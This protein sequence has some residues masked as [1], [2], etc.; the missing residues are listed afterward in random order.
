MNNIFE[1]P[2]DIFDLEEVSGGTVSD[3][4][5]VQFMPW[6][7]PRKQYVRDKQWWFHLSFLIS[8]FPA[9]RELKVIKYFGLP[10]EELLDVNYLSKKLSSNEKSSDKMLLVHGFIDTEKGKN[11]AEVRLSELL[12]RRNISKDSKVERFNFHAL[13][14][15]NSIAIDKIK[16]NGAY[17]LINLDFCDAIFKQ[18]TIDSIMELLILQF[19]K[20]IDTPWLLFLTTRSDGGG[21]SKELLD[22]LDGIFKSHICD[23]QS[24]LASL[25]K[26]KSRIFEYA[27]DKRSLVDESISESD[28]SEILQACLI[29]WIM[30]LTHTNRSNIEVVSVMKYHVYN[31]NEFPDMFSYV[32]RFTKESVSQPDVL[33]LA[34]PTSGVNKL[35]DVID[36]DTCKDN[37]VEKLTK[38][39]DIDMKL[40]SEP[41]L[42]MHYTEEMK[43]LL[44]ELG[45][46][47]S[48]YDEILNPH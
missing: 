19:S 6:H 41:T 33:G 32:F 42:L 24:F 45:L 28:L 13:A 12:D 37:A 10:G 29:Y 22:A 9:Y 3:C 7:K 23:D 25:E 31:G 43:E 30:N 4:T 26:F 46:D 34:N 20:L 1:S 27:R 35:T 21:I 44:M 38:S 16:S 40:S 17:H 11:Q 18:D 48:R 14:D 47:V 2:N 39:L 5:D 36:I 15:K 8:R